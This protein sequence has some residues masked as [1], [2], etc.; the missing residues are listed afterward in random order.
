[1]F[2]YFNQKDASSNLF[3]LLVASFPISF[4]AGNMIINI[5][6]V[7][8]ILS[9]LI[10]HGKSFFNTR[11]YFLDKIIF[12]F[13]SFIIFTALAND[14]FFFQEKLQWK[15]YFST[16]IKSILFLKYLLLYLSLRVLIENNIL[17][18]KLFF[19]SCTLSTLFVCFDL[20]YQGIYGQDIF[21][22]EKPK[23]GRKLGGPFDDELIAGGYIQRFSLFSFF[24]I[25]LFYKEKFSNFIKFIIPIFFVIFLSGIIISGNRMPL[26]LFV[27]TIFLVIIFQK[28]TRKY[29]FSFLI[30]FSLIFSLIFTLNETVKDNFYSFQ[31]QIKNSYTAIKSQ[32]FK[33]NNIPSYLK[34]FATFYDTWLLNK[35]I[36]GGIKNFR[37]Y[38]H[39]RPN[40]EK[41]SKFICNM[42]PHNYYLEVLTET[43][44]IG[45]I[46]LINI[47]ILI[48]Y[49]SFFKKY[50][51]KSVL[52][53][54]IV[55]I[56][57]I[58]LF[59]TEIFPLK[60][61]GSF[62]TTGNSTY[63]FLIIGIMIGLIRRK[64]F[65]E[66]NN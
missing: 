65:I 49:L 25:P 21:G 51:S 12:L 19:M 27:F 14:Y 20:F 56:P 9:T 33:S 5:N 42:H 35:Y 8:L 36:G 34:E 48:L 16:I 45:F 37:Y 29:F 66:N 13:F 54:D 38:C 62:F 59:I 28:Q 17:K 60:S 26:L 30:L 23:L 10:I 43:G 41:N 4:I 24:L 32:D 50:F 22:F 44:L 18:L 6:I 11:Y 7:L 3:N 53:N 61:T 52:N 31:Q 40:I 64:N 57:F 1:M 39:T 63:L 2:A 47:F 55:I 46:M 58:F 15:G